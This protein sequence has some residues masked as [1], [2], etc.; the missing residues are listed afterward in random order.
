MTAEEKIFNIAFEADGRKYTG[1]VNPSDKLNDDGLPA[2]F[3]VVLNDV[4]FGYVS[5]NNG[6]WTVNED[7]PA[8][9]IEKVG[10]AIE[11][12]YTV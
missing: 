1:W 5:H 4:S 12:Q 10:K 8:G 11:K 7:R 9:L 3:H 6:D 2:S